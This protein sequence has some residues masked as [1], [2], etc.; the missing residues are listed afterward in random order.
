MKKAGCVLSFIDVGTCAESTLKRIDVDFGLEDIRKCCADM[1][2]A[3][4][5]F[6][7]LMFFGGPGETRETVE[8][9]LAFVEET[10]PLMV[11]GE[12]GMRIYPNTP[13]AELALKEGMISEGQDLYEPA[14]YTAKEVE[15]WMH[16]RLSKVADERSGFAF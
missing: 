14:F 4:L 1:R 12:I 9:S 2:S 5:N 3:E 13:L 8:E 10:D 11:G 16:E 15:G 6:G 7:F